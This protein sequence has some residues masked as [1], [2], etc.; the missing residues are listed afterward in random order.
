MA[1]LGRPGR[2]VLPAACLL[3][4][5][6][7]ARSE[8]GL[9]VHNEFAQR[10]AECPADD[11][12]GRMRL[13]D[14]ARDNDL[15]DSA[16][17]LYRT[18]LQ[19]DARH[20]QA[21]EA[22]WDL[23]RERP[24]PASSE[25][26]RMTKALLTRRGLRTHETPHFVVLSNAQRRWTQDKAQL[27]ERT[28]EEFHRTAEQLDL[29]PLPLRHKLVCLLLGK[30]SQFVEFARTND[31]VTESWSLGYYSP[32]Y[33]RTVFYNGEVE[34][35]ADE[36]ARH[37]STATTIHEAIHQLLFHTRVQSVHTQYP[38]WS[39]EG[40]ATAFETSAPDLPFGPDREFEPRRQ[41]FQRFLRD[42]RLLPLR[43]FV[44]LDR[45][46][47]NRPESV[48]TMYSQSYAVMSWLARYRQEGLRDYMIL[49][50]KEPP[51]RLSA[52]RHLEIFEQAFGDVGG[53]ERAWLAREKM[54]LSG[55][56]IDRWD[57]AAIVMESV[58][59]V[60]GF[61]ATT[62]PTTNGSEQ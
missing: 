38:L 41:R 51:G 5:T 17:T 29:R 39:C 30:R 3:L 52:D 4:I 54:G 35:G 27:L 55:A 58:S 50:L 1:R 6:P 11:V 53:V 43:S 13:A 61:R 8:N 57:V 19:L 20:E 22:L 32:R 48:Q 47:D 9:D 49:M 34:A 46:P 16:E 15:P 42:D 26:L 7:A 40:F 45:M 31:N 24:L 60:A 62:L 21:Y 36:F 44:Q 37:R 59:A 56:G 33:D 2:A 23:S 10:L 14:W 28:Y 25:A 18:V 12:G